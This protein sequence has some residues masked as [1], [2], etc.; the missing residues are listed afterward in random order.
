MP[1]D[2][3][4]DAEQRRLYTIALD[5][6]KAVIEAVR[7]GVTWWELHG[8]AERMLADAGGYDRYWTYGIGHF[9]GMEVHDEGDYEVPLQPGMALSIE[10]GVAP[11]DGARVAFEDDVIVT[12]D[13]FE[14]VSRSI[15]IEIDEV[16]AMLRE[17][18][19]LAAFGRKGR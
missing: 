12:E 14:W 4:F 13:G 7:P 3:T 10:Q 17:G 2:G 6:Q 11:P 16:E 5:V 15:P 19:N 9:I 1:A 8:I 18:S